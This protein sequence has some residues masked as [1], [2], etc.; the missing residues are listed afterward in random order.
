[1]LFNLLMVKI[2]IKLIVIVFNVIRF[3]LLLLF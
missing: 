3:T 2:K 1:M